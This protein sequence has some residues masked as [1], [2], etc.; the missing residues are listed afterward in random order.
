LPAQARKRASTLIFFYKKKLGVL[1][2]LFILIFIIIK[3]R[4]G[5]AEAKK[6]ENMAKG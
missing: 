4:K 5:G 6:K 2:P 1:A 3:I